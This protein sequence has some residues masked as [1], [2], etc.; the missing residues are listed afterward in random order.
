MRKVGGRQVTCIRAMGKQKREMEMR[1]EKSWW[2]TGG[3]SNV[4]VRESGLKTP[5]HILKS[6]V[7]SSAMAIQ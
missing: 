2:K 7:A 5:W 3:K 1:G 6:S 4:S